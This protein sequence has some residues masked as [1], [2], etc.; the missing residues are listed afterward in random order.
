MDR[1][2]SGLTKYPQGD[3]VLYEDVEEIILYL[4]FEMA[5]GRRKPSEG[6]ANQIKDFF[7]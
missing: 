7:K 1:Y 3:W 5:E 4:I 2:G 6:L